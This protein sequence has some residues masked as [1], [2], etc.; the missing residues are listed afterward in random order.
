MRS[1]LGH[2]SLLMTDLEAHLRTMATLRCNYALKM[3]FLF[4]KDVHT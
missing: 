3:Y 1:Q 2:A 4:M